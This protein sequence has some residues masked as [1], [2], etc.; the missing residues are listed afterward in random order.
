MRSLKIKNARLVYLALLQ[1][2]SA[3]V[4]GNYE[5]CGLYPSVPA[6]L[7]QP[8]PAPSTYNQPYC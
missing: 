2:I 6:P 8:A 3:T 5:Q 4:K 7:T 1:I